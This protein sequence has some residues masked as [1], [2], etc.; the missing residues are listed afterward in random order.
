MIS[1][2]QIF[3]DGGRWVELRA[4]EGSGLQRTVKVSTYSHMIATLQYI[5]WH[6]ME[7][8]IQNVPATIP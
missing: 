7:D 2:S 3:V 4:Q 1:L 6:Y 5:L 8:K